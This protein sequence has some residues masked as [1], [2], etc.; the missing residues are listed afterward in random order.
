MADRP[1]VRAEFAQGRVAGTF[2]VQP[3]GVILHGSRSGKRQDALKE[4]SGTVNWAVGNPAG[5]GWHATIGPGVYGAHMTARQWGWN[6][7][8]H[9]RDFLAVEF[10]Q[11]TIDDPITDAMVAAFVEWWRIEVAP[12]WPALTPRVLLLPM[13]SELPAGKRDGKTDAF[14]AGSAEADDLR[15][16]IYAALEDDM[17][18]QPFDVG[19]GIAAAMER[20][21][22]RPASDEQYVK[23]A[24][25]AD[26]LS[27]AAGSGGGLFIYHAA[28]DAVYRVQ[29]A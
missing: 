27:V 28:S 1:T 20:A 2:A 16:R 21:K 29:R 6:A 7:R 13:H 25:G 17:R 22:E 18:E 11:P 10:A 4:Y 15:R 24:D 12:V 14:R 3:R 5:L 26:C 23:D 9:S 8:E 19:P